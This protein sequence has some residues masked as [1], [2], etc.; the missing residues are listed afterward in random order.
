MNLTRIFIRICALFC[1]MTIA[2]LPVST[3]AQEI[4]ITEDDLAEKPV[5]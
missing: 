3:L 4:V 2:L 1:G 5:Y